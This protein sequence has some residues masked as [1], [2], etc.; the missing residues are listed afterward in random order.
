MNK[1]EQLREERVA[2]ARARMIELSTKFVDRTKTELQTLRKALGAGDAA[3]IVEI[4]YLAHRMAGTGA[5]LGFENLADHAMR[6]E[7]VCDRQAGAASLDPAARDEIATAV[8][9]IDAE[10]R[11][12]DRAPGT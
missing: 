7:A 2:A 6:V 12:L 11:M 3:A 4:R 1:E 5:T 9:A 10:L 8:E